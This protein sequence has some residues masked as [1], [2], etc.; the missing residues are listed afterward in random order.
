MT[1][2]TDTSM[3]FLS[4][5]LFFVYVQKLHRTVQ[6]VIRCLAVIYVTKL[7]TKNKVIFKCTWIVE[8]A[9]SSVIFKKSCPMLT[10]K[11]II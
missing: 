4:T 8:Q 7:R 9:D 11:I 10:I 3:Q 5:I 1:F 6:S 2:F